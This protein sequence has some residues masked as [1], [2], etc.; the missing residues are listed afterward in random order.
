A[1][2]RSSPAGD[3]SRAGG[4]TGVRAP[5]PSRPVWA[6][7]RAAPAPR[8]PAP[9]GPR[10]RGKVVRRPGT[11]IPER[12]ASPAPRAQGRIAGAAAEAPPQGRRIRGDSGAVGGPW[13]GGGVRRARDRAGAEIPTGPAVARNGLRPLVGVAAASGPAGRPSERASGGLRV[14]AIGRGP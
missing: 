6:A 3:R 7:R 2:R 5:S 10:T 8:S 13:C 14:A 9:P 12:I 11:G 1:D 4:R